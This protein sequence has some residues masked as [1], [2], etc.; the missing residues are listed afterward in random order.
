[1]QGVGSEGAGDGAS[2]VGYTEGCV[3]C[4]GVG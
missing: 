4:L 2:A 3:L 1:V